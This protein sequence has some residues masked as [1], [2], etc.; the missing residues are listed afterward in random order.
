MRFKGKKILITSALSG[1]YET[2]FCERARMF[3]IQCGTTGFEALKAG[4]QELIR[5]NWR[6][7]GLN[8]P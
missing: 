1:L 5:N 6:I 7:A 8:L 4:E 2:A 3:F